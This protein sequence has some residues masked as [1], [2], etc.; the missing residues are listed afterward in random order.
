MIKWRVGWSWVERAI[1][2]KPGLEK[3]TE[4]PHPRASLAEGTQI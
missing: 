3:G 2:G 4:G 1:N